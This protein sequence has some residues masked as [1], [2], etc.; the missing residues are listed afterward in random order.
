[1][2]AW[3]I[4]HVQLPLIHAYAGGLRRCYP[5]DRVSGSLRLYLLTYYLLL[6]YYLL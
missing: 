5:D 2:V 4:R 6:S 1:M 3:K